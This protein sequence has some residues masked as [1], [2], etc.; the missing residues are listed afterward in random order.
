MLSSKGPKA[1]SGEQFINGVSLQL[2]QG[3]DGK[4]L[5]YIILLYNSACTTLNF[6]PTR[7][8]TFLN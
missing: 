4:V 7:R 2:L 3:K 1:Q 6:P 5:S 8:E